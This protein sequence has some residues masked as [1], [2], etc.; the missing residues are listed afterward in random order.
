LGF[1]VYS[2]LFAW[3]PTPQSARRLFFVSIIYLPLLLL[4]M[5]LDK[6]GG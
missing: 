2:L 1:I 3:R 5:T 6:S 4:L